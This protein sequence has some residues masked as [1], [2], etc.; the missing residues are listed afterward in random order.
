MAL[1]HFLWCW[2]QASLSSKWK[3]EKTGKTSSWPV[4][5]TEPTHGVLGGQ[6]WSGL[7]LIYLITAARVSPRRERVDERDTKKY[8]HCWENISSHLELRS[9]GMN[10]ILLGWNYT[11]GKIVFF[12]PSFNLM[13]MSY[14]CL[15]NVTGGQSC[16]QGERERTDVCVGQKQQRW[17]RKPS[18]YPVRPSIELISGGEVTGCRSW[19]VKLQGGENQSSEREYHLDRRFP[20][21]W[22][23]IS[24]SLG[25]NIQ[26]LS[27]ALNYLF[28]A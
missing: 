19:L 27:S 20:K 15:K 10:P 21:E 14:S 24:H 8:P 28:W 2:R 1:L 6:A 16:F 3:R 4:C 17:G 7:C 5:P 25:S 12:L 11:K 13:Y 9:S 18:S 26:L 23:W 22:E